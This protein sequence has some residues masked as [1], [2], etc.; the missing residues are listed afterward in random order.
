MHPTEKKK[1]APPFDELNRLA[2]KYTRRMEEADDLV[3]DLLA[4]AVRK[5]K[6][7]TADHFMAWAHGVLRNRAAFIARTEG[8]RRK[9]EKAIQERDDPDQYRPAFPES[10]I[11]SLSPSLRITARFINCGLNQKEIEYL[12]GI[13]NQTLRQRFTALRK[14]W[15]AFP[16]ATGSGPEYRKEPVH[17]PFDIGLLRRSLRKSFHG[18]PEKMIGTFDP[19]GHLFIV[20]SDSSHKKN[21]G[22]NSNTEEDKV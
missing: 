20:R 13:S 1:P 3:Q 8:R 12:L 15:R 17:D 9:R 7:F 19:D 5:E 21:S 22:G 16:E 4:E 2:R 11:E 18:N 10:F 14:K 6:D